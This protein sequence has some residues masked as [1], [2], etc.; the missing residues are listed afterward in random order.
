MNKVIGLFVLTLFFVADWF[1]VDFLASHMEFQQGAE[2]VGRFFLFIAMP[3]FLVI[4]FGLIV[5]IC[6]F[7]EW[8]GEHITRWFNDYLGKKTVEEQRKNFN[9]VFGE[10]KE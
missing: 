5:G 9:E 7:A 1:F 10:P 8:I 6:E 3:C 4:A 2:I